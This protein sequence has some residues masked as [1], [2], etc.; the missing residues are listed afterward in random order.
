MIFLAI[1]EGILGLWFMRLPESPKYL[2]A[3]GKKDEALDIL[4]KMFALNKGKSPDEYPV[5]S[6]YC[7]KENEGINEK[8]GF[9]QKAAGML[10]D[11][12]VQMKSLFKTPLLFVTFL[13]CTIMFTNM[14]G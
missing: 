8:S 6:L 7:P 9:M 11:M 3:I 1:P 10:R 4:K 14:F 12:K 5:N 13:S 2:L